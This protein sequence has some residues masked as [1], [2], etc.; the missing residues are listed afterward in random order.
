[1]QV[2]ELD[3]SNQVTRGSSRLKRLIRIYETGQNS[4]LMDRV[5]DKVFA[6]E[7]ADTIAAIERLDVD[8]QTYEKQYGMESEEFDRKFHAGKLGD[9]M[10]FIEWSSLI[11]MRTHLQQRLEALTGNV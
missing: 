9:Q 1:M 6:Q 2:V 7:A 11:L 3:S 5:L 8:I 4:E 10:D